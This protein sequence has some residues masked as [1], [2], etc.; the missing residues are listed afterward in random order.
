MLVR[1]IIVVLDAVTS[2]IELLLSVRLILKLL[3]AK[4]TA[5]FSAWVYQSTNPL[6]KPFADV[7]PPFVFVGSFTLE[8]ATLFALFIYGLGGFLLQAFIAELSD[9]LRHKNK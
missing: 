5:A 3:R 7:F 2:S 6:V 9:L 8:T 1:Y 4:Q